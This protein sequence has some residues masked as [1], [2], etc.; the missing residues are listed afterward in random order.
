[1]WRFGRHVEIV[2]G[3]LPGMA[4]GSRAFFIALGL[5]KS[6]PYVNDFRQPIVTNKH[7]TRYYGLGYSDA[8]HFQARAHSSNSSNDLAVCFLLEM[9]DEYL[10][11]T[12]LWELTRTNILK[13]DQIIRYTLQLLEAV[14]NLHSQGRVLTTLTTDNIMVNRDR[15]AVKIVD[16]LNILPYYVHFFWPGYTLEFLHPDLIDLMWDIW[17]LGCTVLQMLTHDDIQFA[18]KHG[19]LGMYDREDNLEEW[20]AMMKAG[21]YPVIPDAA[22][23]ILRIFCQKCFERDPKYQLTAKALTDFLLRAQPWYLPITG[24]RSCLAYS[25]FRDSTVRTLYFEWHRIIGAGRYGQV[26][27]VIV[28]ENADLSLD[29]SRDLFAIKVLRSTTIADDQQAK[30][31]SPSHPSIIKYTAIGQL[32]GVQNG[33]FIYPG[34]QVALLMEYCAGGTLNALCREKQLDENQVL[35]YFRQIVAGVQY[36]HEGT[37]SIFHGDIK[38]DSI[39]L[40]ENTTICKLGDL[41]NFSLLLTEKKM[42][43]GTLQHLSPEMLEYFFGAKDEDDTSLKIIGK[44]SDIWSIGCTVLEMVGRGM[45]S[46]KHDQTNLKVEAIKP[47][48]FLQQVNSGAHPDQSIAESRLSPNMNLLVAWCLIKDPSARPTAM[49][50]EALL[51]RVSRA[52]IEAHVLSSIIG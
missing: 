19:S 29:E 37:I 39:F 50:L 8:A 6:V 30:L 3:L 52:A 28:S 1:M 13:E 5:D 4:A 45:V 40:T 12:L 11:V 35:N 14:D 51:T 25:K 27:V 31:L 10:P 9:L 42:N 17:R 36:L 48:T 47:K 22:P 18:D 44:E 16:W 15:T 21:G 49:V 32:H 43:D 34:P 24:L 38:G 7:L 2:K 33:R 41:E 26:F 23:D 46:F 20:E